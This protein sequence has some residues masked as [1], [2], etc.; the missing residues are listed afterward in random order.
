M[1]TELDRKDL[2]ALV[3]GCPPGYSQMDHPLAKKAGH[4]YSDQYGRHGYNDLNNL[5]ED[6]L[7]EL[8]TICKMGRR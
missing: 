6:E 7:F 3:I 1:K 2:E 4:W 5:S 8:Y